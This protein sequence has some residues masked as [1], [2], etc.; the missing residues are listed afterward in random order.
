MN[1]LITGSE[2]LR[3]IELLISLTKIDSDNIKSAIEDVF[4]RGIRIG[5]SATINSVQ[6]SD[7]SKYV[8]RIYKIAETVE[9]IKEIDWEKLKGL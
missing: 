4:V 3:K 9:Q 8:K 7:L 1:Y 2:P 6:Q 5:D